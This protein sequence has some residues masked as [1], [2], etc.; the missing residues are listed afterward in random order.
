MLRISKIRFK[1]TDK[2]E[3]SFEFKHD[4][5]RY[6]GICFLAELGQ[7]NGSGGSNYALT[8]WEGSWPNGTAYASY[9]AGEVGCFDITVTK[10]DDTHINIK[11]TTLNRN[12][13][14][15]VLWMENATYL[16]CGAR[17]NDSGS[18]YGP[19][20]IRNVKVEEL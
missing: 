16:S 5:I 13:N 10:I 7:Y 17:H 9:T 8:T 1:N 19:C 14:V 6:T 12:T 11:S 4:N 2:W 3:L 15:E 20:R 18:N